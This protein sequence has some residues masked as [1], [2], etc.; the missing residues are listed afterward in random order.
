M[1]R[2][3]AASRRS[4]LKA[5]LA[6]A[7]FSGARAARADTLADVKNRGELVCATEMEFAPFDFLVND[8]YTGVDRDLID[9]I[10]KDL[11]VKVKYLDLPWTSVLPGLEAK[12]FD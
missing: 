12:K 3:V 4:V 1:V 11:G 6:A 5:G 8:E 10:G 9:E 2:S 7:A